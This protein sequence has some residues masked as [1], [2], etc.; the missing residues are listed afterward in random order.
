MRVSID[1]DLQSV[2][3]Y[4]DPETDEEW[5][6]FV[7]DHLAI[8]RAGDAVRFGRI[9]RENDS[10]SIESVGDRHVVTERHGGYTSLTVSDQTETERAEALGWVDLRVAPSR[11]RRDTP[12]RELSEDE[13]ESIPS[14]IIR[15]IDDHEDSLVTR[16]TGSV[17]PLLQPGESLQFGEV[18]GDAEDNGTKLTEKE[19]G[20]V[21]RIGSR[22]FVHL[23]T[24]HTSAEP[25]CVTV[26]KVRVSR[27]HIE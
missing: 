9:K 7:V 24:E 8:P 3:T 13:R 23:A 16:H 14:V 19:V 22:E 2:I 4:Q 17:L 12:V 1:Q 20:S 6:Q 18:K 10:T 5:H 25:Y 21:Y 11:E 27:A 15:V 26:V